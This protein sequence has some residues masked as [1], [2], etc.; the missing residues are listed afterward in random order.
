MRY[1]VSAVAAAV[2][3]VAMLPAGAAQAAPSDYGIA[4]AKAV[5][6]SLQAGGH[7]D[8]ITELS[9]KREPDGSLPATSRDVIADLPPGLLAN[10]TAVPVCDAAQFIATD[11]DDPSNKN[12]CPQASQVGVAEIVLFNADGGTQSITEPLF[13]V[14]PRLG[15]PARLGFFARFYPV[16]IDTRLRPED[17]YAGTA[18]SENVGSLIPLVSATIRAWGVPAD[19]SHDGERIT[20]YE[21]LHNGGVP[22]TPTGRRSA[23]LVPAPYV[24]N[25]TRCG[26][27]HGVRFTAIPYALPEL[28]STLFAPLAPIEACGLLGF[29]P[30]ISIDPTTAQAET[31]SGLDVRLDFPTAGFER[32]ELFADSAARRVEI[33]LPEGITVNPSQAVGLG[34]CSE[35]D[36]ARETYSSAPGQ[37]CPESSR[38]GT[39]TARS[40][41]IEESAEGG[42]FIATPRQNPFHTLIALYLVLKVPER[43]VVV[44]LAGKVEPDS[45]TGQLVTTFG[46]PGHE[47]PQLP[48]SSFHLH[49]REG[50]RSPLVTP[51]RCGR[52]AATAKFTP[53]SDAARTVVEHP[54]FEISSGVAGGPCPAGTPPFQ[55]GFTARSLKLN[56][57][58]Y[59]PFYMRLSR[60]DG[61]QDLTRFST[62][63]PPGLTAKLAGLS[64]CPDAAIAAAKAKTGSAEQVSPSCPA[65]SRIGSVLAGAGVGQV[66]TYAE[67]N[68]YLAGPSNG[69]PL[70]VAAIVPAVAGPFDVGTVVT[71]VALRVDPGSGE[72]EVDG[73][74]SDP[75]PHILAGIPLK[76]R[77]VRVLTDRPKF[78]LNPTSC[79]PLRTVARLWGGGNDVFSSLDDAPISLAERFQAAD[80]ARLGFRPRLAL[81]LKGGSQRAANP[82]LRGV[83]RPRKGDANLSDLALRL[84]RSAFLDQAH[85]RTICTRAQYNAGRGNGAECPNGAVYGYAKAWTPLLD[86]PLQG[87]V[88]LRSSRHE[89]PDLVAALHGLIDVE[90]PARIDSANGIRVVFSNL[91][92]A[93]LSK[94]VVAMRGGRRG[95]IVNSTNLCRRPLRGDARFT[96]HSGRR[97]TA[98]P[99]LEVACGSS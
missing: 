41:L 65:S 90:A 68:L 8:F 16:L 57:G 1:Y 17:E 59:T 60:R 43:G 30:D 27:P 93:P 40:P 15:E 12:G 19:E 88:F 48:V 36:L 63:L 13:N 7:P 77:E 9:L 62:R 55:P 42:L 4:S 92:D 82:A 22:E 76:V 67:G 97:H 50:A 11:V 53:W 52:Y 91:P 6:S 86:D 44:K 37:G 51:S 78:T 39:V 64:S 95:L 28:R 81:R 87:P 70:S 61:D 18:A 74:A 66:L 25:P 45:R 83:Y 98:H 75:I 73:S 34:V 56:A 80:C 38:I 26:V 85:I 94:V 20:A 24:V 46:E 3:A 99:V 71:R 14:S 89:L 29:S 49:F 23:G 35:A 10:P 2:A 96:A 79:E 69:A 47:I 54:S 72:V 31:G 33:A 32:P 5:L 21:A 58:A 84:P